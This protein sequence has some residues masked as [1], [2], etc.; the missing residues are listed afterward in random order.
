MTSPMFKALCL[1]ACAT[2]LSGCFE[3]GS[4]G[5]SSADNSTTPNPGMDNLASDQAIDFSR[6]SDPALTQC[7]QQ[8]GIEKIS[9]AQ[10]ISCPEQ[11]IADLTGIE[12]LSAARIVSLP[13]NQITDLTPLAELN[14]L[15]S[16]DVDNN[17]V[18]SLQPLTQQTSLRQLSAKH[19]QLSD[20][21]GLEQSQ[22]NKL[23]V[24]HNPLR[25]LTVLSS[26]S[27]LRHVSAQGHA[28]SVPTLAASVKSLRL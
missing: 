4:S 25:D 11:Q 27:Q 17:K 12:Q 13:H 14:G 22:I 23:Y 10:I 24:D 16:L 19:N 1:A 15:F 8:Q 21:Q 18:Q 5:S 9:Q 2:A 28:A 7:L 3:Q 26:M 6:F 20:L